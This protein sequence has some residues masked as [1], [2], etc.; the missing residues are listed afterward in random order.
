MD[1]MCDKIYKDALI[2]EHI[3]N[4]VGFN[5][6]ECISDV[7][8]SANINIF[9][10]YMGGRILNN[11]TAFMKL[12]NDEELAAKMKASDNLK[13]TIAHKVNKV[14]VPMK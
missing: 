9:R 3:F 13:G 4:N 6:Y 12:A 10:N 7:E 11:I 2:L 14:D 8:D 5:I 1:E